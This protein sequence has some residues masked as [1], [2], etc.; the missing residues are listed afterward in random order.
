[1]KLVFVLKFFNE[2]EINEKNILSK[3]EK[4]KRKKK[5]EKIF[6]TFSL[7]GRGEETTAKTATIAT[8]FWSNGNRNFNRNGNGN[9]K[10]MLENGIVLEPEFR[11]CS[12][13]DFQPLF[14]FG[15]RVPH[16]MVFLFFFVFFCFLLFFLFFC[17]FVFLFF[18]FFVFFC[19]LFFVFCFFFFCFLFFFFFFFLFFFILKTETDD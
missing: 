11:V 1:M 13:V 8:Q 17:F 19:F 9:P 15:Q 12:V 3:K 10:L 4:K 5:R 14:L 16:S 2:V 18:C 7:D 6:L